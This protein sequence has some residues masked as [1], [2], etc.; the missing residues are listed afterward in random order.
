M[1]DDT[2]LLH[3]LLDHGR[4]TLQLVG[5]LSEDRFA[6][7]RLRRL[8]VERLVEILGEAAS[9]LD[10]RTRRAVEHDW[11]GLKAL[12]NFIAH[13]YGKVEAGHLLRIVRKQLPDLVRTLEGRLR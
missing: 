5:G 1:D 2:D 9:R 4:E 8:A 11:D 13:Q 10:P 7:D 3:D 6:R 12:R